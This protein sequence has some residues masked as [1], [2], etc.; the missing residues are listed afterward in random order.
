M[1]REG[2]SSRLTEY[3]KRLVTKITTL[4]NSAYAA[5]LFTTLG[6]TQTHTSYPVNYPV[7]GKRDKR[8]P[9]KL[10]SV[11]GTILHFNLAAGDPCLAF[12][13]MHVGCKQRYILAANKVTIGVT[14]CLL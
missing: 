10:F 9:Y 13:Y 2:L 6:A 5:L 11:S 4:S 12:P 7:S 1:I 3:I 8:K 14:K